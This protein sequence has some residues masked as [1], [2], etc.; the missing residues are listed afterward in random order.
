M[1]PHHTPI[2]EKEIIPLIAR[3]ATSESFEN[4]MRKKLSIIFK[5]GSE[6]I[7]IRPDGEKI[8][9]YKLNNP[10]RHFEKRFKLL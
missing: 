8:V 5:E 10:S 6:I 2:K 3:K 9:K 7:E 4:A 1:K